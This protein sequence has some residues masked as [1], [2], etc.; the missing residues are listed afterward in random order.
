MTKF[1]FTLIFAASIIS[2]AMAQESS[3]EEKETMKEA[4]TY[5]ESVAFVFVDKNKG[6]LKNMLNPKYMP[7]PAFVFYTGNGID[8]S[9]ERWVLI[10]QNPWQYLRISDRMRCTHLFGGQAYITFAGSVLLSVP[11]KGSVVKFY[12]GGAKQYEVDTLTFNFELGKHYTIDSRVENEVITEFSIKE[13]DT[14]SYLAFQAA[15]PNRFDGTWSSNEGKDKITFSFDGKKMKFEKKSGKKVY[16][17]EGSIMFNE[18]T[19]IFFTEKVI[20]YEKEIK[21]YSN[22]DTPY[23]WYYTLNN[24]VLHFIEGRTIRHITENNLKWLSTVR[25]K[26]IKE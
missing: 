9:V 18:N 20:Q 13:T 3:N 2:A 7:N 15:N 26:L 21:N 12:S 14:N 10:G 24:N 16:L 25:S 11:R 23:I 19:I 8:A 1:F 17:A 22:I 4:I 6:I 5:A